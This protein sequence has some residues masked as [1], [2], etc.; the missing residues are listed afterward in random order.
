MSIR[1]ISPRSDLPLVE[2]WPTFRLH[3]HHQQRDIVF[4]GCA[5]RECRDL[6]QNTVKNLLGHLPSAGGKEVFESLLSPQFTITTL[7]FDDSV[8]AGHQDV[9]IFQA[10]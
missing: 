2:R 5:I 1:T 4:L 3:L 7:R 6:I 10:E 8:G 9:A